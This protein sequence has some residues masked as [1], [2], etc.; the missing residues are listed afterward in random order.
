MNTT[1]ARSTPG[2]QVLRGEERRRSQR[3][4]IRMPVTLEFGSDGKRVT[5]DAMTESVNDHGSMLLCP[6]TLPAETQ[7]Q[8]K[9]ERTHQQRLCRVA[10][11]P[12][13]SADGFLI[14]VEFNDP[15]PGF[16][17]IS[18]PPSNWKPVEE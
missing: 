7:L 6:R 1:E 10:R 16:W 18:F 2:I 11:A 15:A 4:L 13:E 17:G 8:I 9:H 14:P 12:I 3:V 5:I